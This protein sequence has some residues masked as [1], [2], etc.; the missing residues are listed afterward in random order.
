MTKRLMA[1]RSMAGATPRGAS[2]ARTVL[3]ALGIALLGG[4]VTPLPAQPTVR[5]PDLGVERR[6]A[7][8]DVL[9]ETLRIE[10][11]TQAWVLRKICLD[12]QAYWIGL[13]ESNPTGI[14]ASFKDGKPEPCSRRGR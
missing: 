7:R 5:L 8:E 9:M 1:H 12:G 13:S 4:A 11:Q 2:T 6:I 10:G 14:A 3:R